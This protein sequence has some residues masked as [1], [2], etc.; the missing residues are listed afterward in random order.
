MLLL[1]Q[2]IVIAHLVAVQVKFTFWDSGS[3]VLAESL[4]EE[5]HLACPMELRELCQC[6]G[7]CWKFIPPGRA[8]SRE[9][10]FPGGGQADGLVVR[11]LQQVC[12][13]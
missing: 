4:T 5:R 9:G 7:L 1:Q 6:S 11:D 10:S 12:I 2:L 8:Q 3:T 13:K